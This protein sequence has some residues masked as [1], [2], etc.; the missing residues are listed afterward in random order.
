[1][2]ATA[3]QQKIVNLKAQLTEEESRPSTIASIDESIRLRKEIAKLRATYA[4][5]LGGNSFFI[6]W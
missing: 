2:D 1:M 4:K 6:P 5:S 3:V